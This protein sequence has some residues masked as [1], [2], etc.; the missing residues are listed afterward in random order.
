[1][2]DE[3]NV[4]ND[5][6]RNNALI[7]VVDDEPVIGEIVAQLLATEG[8]K[9]KFF[10]CSEEAYNSLC[11]SDEKPDLLFTDYQMSVLNGI[12]LIEK[13]REKVPDLKTILYSG[14]IHE[15][16]LVQFDTK[17]NCFI[18]KPFE[19]EKMFEM[20]KNLLSVS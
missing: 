18:R 10:Q 5:T 16:S 9:T 19:P 6:E 4:K 7:Y 3:K 8:Y 2:V 17:P 14:N 15:D 12:E 20:V 1:M 11:A 13:C